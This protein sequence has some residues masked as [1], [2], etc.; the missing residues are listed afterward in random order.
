M[1]V[2][3]KQIIQTLRN[4]QGKIRLTARELG[5]SPGTVINW[6][7]RASSI[8]QGWTSTLSTR[9]LGRKS[10][11]PK[12]SRITTLSSNAQLEIIGLRKRRG[13]GAIK[14]AVSLGIPRQHRSVHRFLKAKG[15]TAPGK[16]YRRPRYQET[17]HMYV[18]KAKARGNSRWMLST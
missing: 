9:G 16:N 12:T 2:E 11:K 6:R 7:R 14:I 1:R 10:T 4:N 5:I 17:T 13:T 3:P 18:A 15:L 8:S